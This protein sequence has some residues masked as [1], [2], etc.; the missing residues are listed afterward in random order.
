MLA[1]GTRKL[2]LLWL[3]IQNGTLFEGAVLF[4]DEPET[5]LNPKL[6]NTAV[7][8]LLELHRLGVQI[9]IATHNYSILK[10]FD[11]Q[12]AKGDTL[13]FHSLY[14]RD[15]GEIANRT[16]DSYLDIYPNAI[17]EAFD[18]LYDREIK[19]SLTRHWA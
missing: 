2:G 8:V 11:L 18:D 16:V 3:L 5:N 12:K 14:H 4:W 13:V 6:F 1:E 7:K 10:E 19:R 17:A 9:F 15:D